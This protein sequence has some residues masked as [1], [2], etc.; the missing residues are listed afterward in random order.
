MIKN[1]DRIK[2]LLWDA[3]VK[4]IEAMNLFDE[5][6]LAPENPVDII[7]PVKTKLEKL[8]EDCIIREGW[9][10]T[11]NWYIKR[12]DE[13][14]YRDVSEKTGVPWQVVASIHALE[15]SCNFNTHLHNG[16][17]LTARTTHV[18]ANRPVVGAPP[19]F[20]EESAIDAL[21]YDN[22]TNVK[23]W[24]VEKTL[25]MLEKYNGKGYFN[26]G[27]NT[28]YLWSGTQFYGDA[29]NIGKYVADGKFN[30]TYVSQQVGAVVFLKLLK[31]KPKT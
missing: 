2:V 29:P 4:L 9:E 28:P 12:M 25:D 26:R 5:E 23:D 8:W 21:A 15:G 13:N 7:F 16:D 31:W 20:W 24:T 6:A 14:K 10:T 19:F 18:P 17:P 30:P 22:L 1:E 27:I 11:A 3:N